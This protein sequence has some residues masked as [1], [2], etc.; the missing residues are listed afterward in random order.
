MHK[1]RFSPLKNRPLLLLNI[2]LCF[3][4]I[5]VIHMTWLVLSC[6]FYKWVII[7]ISFRGIHQALSLIRWIFWLFI[8]L[9]EYLFLCSELFNL[10]FAFGFSEISCWF[11]KHLVTIF[12]LFIITHFYDIFFVYA[13]HSRF[14]IIRQTVTLGNGR[15]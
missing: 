8:F 13:D 15:W 7:A 5:I 10:D 9:F 12:I 11:D 1:Y 2:S 6:I 4:R 3:S 14:L